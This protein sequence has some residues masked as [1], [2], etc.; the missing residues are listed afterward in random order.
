MYCI[1]YGEG[2]CRLCKLDLHKGKSK[3]ITS[4]WYFDFGIKKCYFSKDYLLFKIGN[5]DGD[6]G[7]FGVNVK[8]DNVKDYRFI[9][10]KD[11]N[12]Y[13]ALRKGKYLKK[14]TKNLHL[15]SRNL[16]M[17]CHL[18]SLQSVI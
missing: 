13:Y 2:Y 9:L 11:N 12:I 5:S 16:S 4:N 8:N 7:G 15:N 10:K 17:I 18:N 14:I 1:V 6:A 3:E